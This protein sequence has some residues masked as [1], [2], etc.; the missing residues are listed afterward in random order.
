M[1]D[2]EEKKRKE[3][4]HNFTLSNDSAFAKTINA[5]PRDR[6]VFGSVLTLMLSISP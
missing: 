6:P 3:I 1:I 2:E 5:K 4:S